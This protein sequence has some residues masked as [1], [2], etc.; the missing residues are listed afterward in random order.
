MTPEE[1]RR[2]L[3]VKLKN[4]QA[5]DAV[6]ARLKRI[7]QKQTQARRRPVWKIALLVG[8]LLVSLS[9]LAAGGYYSVREFMRSELPGDVPENAIVPLEQVFT[10]DY[11][12]VTLGDAYFDNERFAITMHLSG[13]KAVYLY[14]MLR[15]YC[16]DRLLSTDVV[17]VR[18]DFFSGFLY[19]SLREEHNAYLNGDYGMNGCLYEDSADE[20]VRWVFTLQAL[21]PN[22]QLIDFE[23]PVVPYD[24]SLTEDENHQAYLDAH[25]VY[26]DAYHQQKI[27]ITHGD[28]VVEYAY[29]IPVPAD[30]TQDEW[31]ALGLTDWLVHSGAFTLVDTITCEYDTDLQ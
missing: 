2:A 31:Y 27:L 28:S 7:P 17:G 30:M 24:H 21:A 29:G 12:T 1:L 5:D 8:L 19:P 20:A 10:N 3:D 22:W 23:P 26:T 15:G 14:P 6:R 18:G 25:R 9:A 13:D 4:I 11:L 16:G